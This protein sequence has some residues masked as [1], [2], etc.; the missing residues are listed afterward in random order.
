M[1]GLCLVLWSPFGDFAEEEYDVLWLRF[2]IRLWVTG[3]ARI[4]SH[5]LGIPAA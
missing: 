2:P 5:S 3:A 4:R 1:D